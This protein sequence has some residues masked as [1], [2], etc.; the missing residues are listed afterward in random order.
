M[1]AQFPLPHELRLLVGL[2]TVAIVVY[3]LVR[4]VEV[5]LILF[6]AGLLMATVAGNPLAVFDTF[7]RA[8]V[9]AM[10]API[11]AAMGF[12]AVLA[13]TG[14]DRHLVRALLAPVRRARWAILPGGILAAYLVNMAVPSQTST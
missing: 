2:L 11:C 4:R 12:A 5:R 9:S 10:V 14:C 6:G 1:A 3:L 7:T 8:M 13:L